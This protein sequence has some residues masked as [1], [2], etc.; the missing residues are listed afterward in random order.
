[1]SKFYSVRDESTPETVYNFL[2]QRKVR[3]MANL[4]SASS[5]RVKASL[6]K[7]EALMKQEKAR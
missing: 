5:R 7:I 2:V 3:T 6:R 1:M 4:K